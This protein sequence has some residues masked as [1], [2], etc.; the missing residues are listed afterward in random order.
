MPLKRE[1]VEKMNRISGSIFYYNV[2]NLLCAACHFLEPSLVS[3]FVVKNLDNGHYTLDQARQEY[4]SRIIE[5]AGEWGKSS[6][7]RDLEKSSYPLR[8]MYLKY[9]FGEYKGEAGKK[10]LKK[11]FGV[12]PPKN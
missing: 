7:K 9:I 1:T 8:D 4:D 5:L 3:A 2:G 12:G 10:R 11:V 6:S